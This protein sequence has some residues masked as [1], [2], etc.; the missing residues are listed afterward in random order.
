M[1]M[2]HTP[3]CYDVATESVGQLLQAIEHGAETDPV[4]DNALAELNALGVLGD[5][6]DTHQ[7]GVVFL[8]IASLLEGHRTIGPMIEAALKDED[9]ARAAY[10]ATMN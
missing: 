2:K 5:P 8:R 1:T 7:R 9:R 3:D 10:F 6:I 4:L